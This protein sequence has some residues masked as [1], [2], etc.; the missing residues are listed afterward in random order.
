MTFV[1]KAKKRVVEKL[2]LI[3]YIYTLSKHQKT[4]QFSDV[5]RGYRNVT[6]TNRLTSGVFIVN[7]EHVSTI[8]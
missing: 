1:K 7:F 5:S 3:I 4:V 6:G 8:I 2:F